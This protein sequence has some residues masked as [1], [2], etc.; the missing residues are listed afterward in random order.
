NNQQSQ[1]GT[2]RGSTVEQ[3]APHRGTVR[4]STVGQAQHRGTSPA[5]WNNQQSQRGTVS[6]RAVEHAVGA[7]GAVF[8]KSGRTRLRWAGNTST[9]KGS[10]VAK[11]RLLGMT[12]TVLAAGIALS[13]C[14]GKPGAAAI[15]DGQTISE[16]A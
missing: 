12:A 14:A 13:G 4:G 8:P 3:V 16:Q 10:T 1:R 15:V 11:P 6:G 2:V 9:A 5:P 7:V